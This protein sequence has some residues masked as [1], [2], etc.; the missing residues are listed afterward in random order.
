MENSLNTVYSFLLLIGAD[1]PQYALLDL[2]AQE[3]YNPRYDF[4][5]K[6]PTTRGEKRE[7]KK[8]GVLHREILRNSGASKFLYSLIFKKLYTALVNN[9]MN[10]KQ[11][12]CVEESCKEFL[13]VPEVNKMADKYLDFLQKKLMR[14][15]NR[16]PWTNNTHK[17]EILKIDNAKKEIMDSLNAAI[18]QKESKN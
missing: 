13:R 7:M 8:L 6:E 12:V 9:D 14:E 15:E 18:S 10:I 16:K 11:L 5:F 2:D 17:E 3:N 4:D 1:N